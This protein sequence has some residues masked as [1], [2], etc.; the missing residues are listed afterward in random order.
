MNGVLAL[1]YFEQKNHGE[2]CW[3]DSSSNYVFFLR[4][5]ELINKVSNIKTIGINPPMVKSEPS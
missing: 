1:G 2:S 4:Q 5:L 3:C